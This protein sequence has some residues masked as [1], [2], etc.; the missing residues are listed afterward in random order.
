VNPTHGEIHEQFLTIQIE[1]VSE[2][3]RH[4]IMKQVVN[5]HARPFLVCFLHTI[6]YI[7]IYCWDSADNAEKAIL[8]IY[9]C[10]M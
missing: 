4:P 7:Y 9:S 5:L 3:R 8:K 10:Y 1:R 6:E 2:R